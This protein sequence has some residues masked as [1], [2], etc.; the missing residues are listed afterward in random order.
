M[1]K[2]L[3]AVLSVSVFA[4]L[5]T[6]SSGQAGTA[7]DPLIT[8]SYA[9]GTYT[10]SVV[11]AGASVINSRIDAILA[12]LGVTD[13]S[14]PGLDVRYTDGWEL[15]AAQVGH[16]VTLVSG[17]SFLLTFGTATVSITSGEVIDIATGQSV[18]SG[19]T[20]RQMSRYFCVED[21]VAVFTSVDGTAFM[22]EGGYSPDSGISRQ[23]SDYDDV[24]GLEWYTD[25]ARYVKTVGLYHDYDAA[26]FRPQDTIT[27]ADLV[28]ALWVAFGRPASDFE[29]TF[30]DLA[31]DWYI[32]AVRWAAERGIVAG[33]DALTFNPMGGV[34]R[35][36]L[37][38]M[39]FRSAAAAGVDVTNRV[40][41]S[42][43]SDWQTITA[44]GFDAISWATAEGY[45]SGMNN[46]TVAPLEPATRAQVASVVMRY[47]SANLS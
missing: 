47:A 31:E 25:P 17:S 4:L 29:P 34:N 38:A 23:Y 8:K 30:Q 24:L 3:A 5:T 37:A 45:I 10:E 41:L 32:P 18:P 15:L 40:D 2:I 26:S 9:D 46:G 6:A 33:M 44:W 43:Y 28:H 7:S 27:R 36:Q 39:L 14:R 12:S 20:L 1:K 13:P 19:S 22:V 42:I 21:T 35:E 16:S 11:N